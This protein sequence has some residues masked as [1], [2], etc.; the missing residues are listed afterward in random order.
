[1]VLFLFL[2]TWTLFCARRN[3]VDDVYKCLRVQGTRYNTAALQFT[4]PFFECKRRQ[5]MV[6]YKYEYQMATNDIVHLPHSRKWASKRPQLRALLVPRR[7]K[8]I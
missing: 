7:M 5:P 2:R 1:M 8:M 6:R 3:G 4:P